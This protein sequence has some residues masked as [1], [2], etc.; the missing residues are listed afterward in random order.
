MDLVPNGR[1]GEF[2]AAPGGSPGNVAV[3]LARLGV[4]ARML[5]RLAD[6]LLGRR[7]RAHLAANGVDLRHAV[8]AQE[9]STL[10]LVAVGPDGGAEYDFRVSGTADWA[11]RDGE[12]EH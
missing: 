10:A 1:D 3:G 9:P 6:G 12:L 5:A 8:R 4:P 11:W 2:A 7:L